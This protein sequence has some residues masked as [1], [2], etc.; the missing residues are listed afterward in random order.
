MTKLLN[1][2]LSLIFLLFINSCS[3]SPDN[4]YKPDFDWRVDVYLTSYDIAGNQWDTSSKYL[5]ET[6][7]FDDTQYLPAYDYKPLYGKTFFSTYM[8]ELLKKKLGKLTSGAFY[9]ENGDFIWKQFYTYDLFNY[10]KEMRVISYDTQYNAKFTYEHTNG[11]LI[12]SYRFNTDGYTQIVTDYE[13]NSSNYISARTEYD[14]SNTVLRTTIYEYD[15]DGFLIRQ[16]NTQD[17]EVQVHEFLYD[18]RGLLIER[19]YN[20]G[21][22]IFAE[23]YTYDSH[24]NLLTVENENSLFRDVYTYDSD[25]LLVEKVKYRLPDNTPRNKWELSYKKLA[26]Y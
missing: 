18:I 12:K 20:M 22:N 16:T 4:P 15:A 3:D 23:Y 26:L 1:I 9:I 2:T 6:Y 14:S 21:S 8:P 11:K 17:D 7:T 19:T 25:N 24:N 5:Y 13:Y 10:L